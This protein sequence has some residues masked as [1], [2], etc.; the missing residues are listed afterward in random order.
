MY[1][2]KFMRYVQRRQR[3]RQFEKCRY[4]I[5]NQ[6]RLDVIFTAPSILRST[7]NI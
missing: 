6:R 4:A 7:R 1:V 2:R 3:V 5:G